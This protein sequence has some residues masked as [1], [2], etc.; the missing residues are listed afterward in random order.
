M[1]NTQ[2]IGLGY[3]GLPT[4]ILTSS[5]GLKTHGYDI[6]ISKLEDISNSNI[7]TKEVG[8]KEN[9]NNVLLNGNLTV[10]NS[11]VSAEVHLIVVPTP[12][13]NKLNPD[14][15]IVTEAIHTII[16]F[17]KAEDLII[18]E[19][20]C[21][22][23]TTEKLKSIIYKARPELTNSLYI[24]YCPER[25]LPGNIFY[26]LKQNDRIVGGI[27]IESSL[28]AKEFYENFVDGKIHLTNSRT[29]EMCK[30]VE[31][32]ARDHQIAFANELSIIC[33]KS[34][35]DVWELISL[36]NKHPRVN[37]LNPGIGVGGH[38]I[39]VDPWFL[40]S[41]FP[42][43]AKNIR[44]ARETNNHKTNWCINKIIEVINVYNIENIT[45][46]RIACMGL[47]Y[48]PNVDDVRESPALNIVNHLIEIGHDIYCV[49]P[50]II[51][52]NSLKIYPL[53]EVVNNVD[54][55]IWLVPHQE[56]KNLNLDQN[57]IQIDLCGINEN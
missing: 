38:C 6:N 22:I 11:V 37:I 24:S 28:K 23:N 50:N 8:L 13:D 32:S 55:V 16:P 18:I 57:V 26:E 4:A 42:N 34:D 39:A 46:P 30:L 15:S 45:P 7:L 44:L 48:K 27:N 36:A 35:I 19:S 52:Y 12:I 53:N 43:E 17:L 10:S 21:P 31:N 49:E 51:S 3:I 2:I 47:S 41:E 5:V 14:I 40:V 9:L 20:T 56:F 1:V 54:I 29:A 25:V 33:D